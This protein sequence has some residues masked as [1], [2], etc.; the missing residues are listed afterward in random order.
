M[1][2]A[3]AIAIDQGRI[4]GGGAVDDGH[5]LHGDAQACEMCDAQP[6]PVGDPFG[7]FGAG[8]R[9]QADHAWRSREPAEQLA[10]HRFHRGQVF[11]AADKCKHGF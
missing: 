8:R 3:P 1:K 5:R 4:V 9:G 7:A 10:V 6:R 11:P 2:L